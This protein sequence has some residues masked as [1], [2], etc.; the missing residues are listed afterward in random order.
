MRRTAITSI[1]LTPGMSDSKVRITKVSRFPHPLCRA[2]LS[3]NWPGDTAR[4]LF[5]KERAT[6]VTKRIHL[7]ATTP[8]IKKALIYSENG[9]D[10]Q[11]L[12]ML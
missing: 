8:Q 10:K 5:T 4:Y 12:G 7:L 2:L 9:E 11:T 1:P 6:L 3:A